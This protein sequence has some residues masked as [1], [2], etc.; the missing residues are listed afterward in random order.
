ME[1]NRIYWIWMQQVFGA[2]SIK[3]RRILERY[4][5]AR[6]FCEA[7]RESWLQDGLFTSAE[8]DRL[9]RG[10]LDK[11]QAQ[12]ALAE[13]LGQSVICPDQPEF[14]VLLREIPALPCAIYYKGEL[15]PPDALCI[16]MVG[17]RK[18][19][20]DGMDAAGQL[21]FDLARKGVV[22]VSGGALGIDSASHI[23]A[24]RAGGRTLCVLGCGL[25][26]KY[27]MQNASLRETIAQNGAVLS[28]FPPGTSPSRKTFPIRNRLISGLC[29]GTV[30]VEAPE[31]SGAL[32]TASTALEQGRDV[33]AVPGTILN[34]E[35]RG[36]NR[37]I[38]DGA[39]P[40]LC[41]EDIL[42]EYPGCTLEPVK[43]K[44]GLAIELPEPPSQSGRSSV[45][46][47]A[48]EKTP[49]SVQA[50]G[51][52]VHEEESAVS[53]GDQTVPD[54]KMLSPD[55]GSLYAVLEREPRHISELSHS[56]GLPLNRALSA[57]T[58]L[59]LGG[60]AR[61]FSGRRFSR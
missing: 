30:V 1:D 11:A 53:A 23:G 45:K 46:T 2:G 60:W 43:T 12:L 44:A 34:P 50:P 35:A 54:P 7:G 8:L 56:A 27:L 17:T 9:S 40:A 6:E 49:V 57:M 10:T 16:A 4:G 39:K 59:E 48:H 55:A 5:S 51:M 15:P 42:E 47:L 38:R 58:E 29:A 13:R 21:S 32:I 14:P 37:M 52:S 3:P 41:A 24:L 36:V 61:S 31:K 22:I 26:Y 19:T 18:A 28:E 33:F 20:R 25:D